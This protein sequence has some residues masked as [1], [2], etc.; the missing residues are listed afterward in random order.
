M[1]AS[2]VGG[3]EV[4]AKVREHVLRAYAQIANGRPDDAS[5]ELVAA[6]ELLRSG[7]RYDNYVDILKALYALDLGLFIHGFATADEELRAL[8]WAI[9]DAR[10]ELQAS[11]YDALNAAREF[12]SLVKTGVKPDVAA[13]QVA[14]SEDLAKLVEILEGY[15]GA[16]K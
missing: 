16:Q 4:T 14:A 3:G 6:Y 7:V 11:L 1:D 9:W 5:S 2:F 8:G 15:A 12:L 13:K 10:N